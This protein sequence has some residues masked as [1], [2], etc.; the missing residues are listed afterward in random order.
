MYIEVKIKLFGPHCSDI[1][2]RTTITAA[3]I[4]Y[5][6]SINSLVVCKVIFSSP[7]ALTNQTTYVAEETDYLHESLFRSNDG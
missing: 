5:I 3:M 7:L 6:E 4:L 1:H 2:I